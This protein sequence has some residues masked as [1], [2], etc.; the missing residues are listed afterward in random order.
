MPSNPPA[1]F[2]SPS[3]TDEGS[4]G[5]W[6]QVWDDM[7]DAALTSSAIATVA[8]IPL[9]AAGHLAA[10]TGVVAVDAYM[11]TGADDLETIGLD[12]PEGRQLILT[13]ADEA[14]PITVVH[15][16]VD[17]AT[18]GE[19]DLFGD[20]NVTISSRRQSL[21]L[22]RVGNRWVERFRSPTIAGGITRRIVD[23]GTTP[24]NLAAAQLGQI[25]KV[26]HASAPATAMTLRLPA[27]APAGAEFFLFVTNAQ[28]GAVTFGLQSGAEF[29]LSGATAY[30]TLPA[31][32]ADQ[33]RVVTMTCTSNA[34]GVSAVWSPGGAIDYG[35][36]RVP[37][38]FEV[39]G[40]LGE[41]GRAEVSSAS[42]SLTIDS[43]HRGK[44]LFKTGA[45]AGTWTVG[46]AGG[47]VTVI[48]AGTGTLTV[49]AGGG[50]PT[51]DLAQGDACVVDVQTSGT[52]RIFSGGSAV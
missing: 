33:S 21:V 45:A 28:T 25:L 10:A 48:N 17:G 43:T 31:P 44:R 37:G 30:A 38:D 47:V 4:M 7:I 42:A 5:E 6:K 46:F 35:A 51:I 12:L 50:S 27:D 39:D 8:S 13:I 49:E 14:R 41:H 26:E 23:I 19:I 11:S 40:V 52:V 18:D 36:Y 29:E 20:A 16:S 9:T 15:Q 1:N 32:P 3:S 24:Y 34:D 2:F 22:Q